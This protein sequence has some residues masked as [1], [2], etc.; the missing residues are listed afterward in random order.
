[1]VHGSQLICAVAVALLMLLGFAGNSAYSTWAITALY[2]AI[3]TFT[4]ND[5]SGKI[6]PII[7]INAILLTLL[8]GVFYDARRLLIPAIILLS[9]FI[10]KIIFHFETDTVMSF[11]TVREIAQI[12]AFFIFYCTALLFLFG[13]SKYAKRISLAF[14]VINIAFIKPGRI[15]NTIFDM[16]IVYGIM[17]VFIT[18]ITIRQRKYLW[19]LATTV[20][21]VFLLAQLPDVHSAAI[22]TPINSLNQGIRTADNSTAFNL[23]QFK[24]DRPINFVEQPI[25]PRDPWTIKL[26][27]SMVILLHYLEKVIVP[28]PLAFYYGYKFIEPQSISNPIPLL[29][30]GIYLLLISALIYFLR[31]NKTISLGIGIYLISVA[32]FSNYF[33]FVPGIVADRFLLTASLGW[34]IIMPAALVRFFNI[35]ITRE[36]LKVSEFP[37]GFIYSFGIVLGLYSFMTISRNFDWKD[38][39]SL[40]KH[41]IS[42]VE[43]SSQAHNLLALN[44]MQKSYDIA[45]PMA[46]KASRLEALGHFKKAVEIYP[47]FY[48]ATYDIAR[49]F[50]VLHENDSSIFYFKKALAI[51]SGNP[52]PALFIG[53]MLSE[54]QQYNEAIP[55]LQYAVA[56]TTGNYEAYD[57]L[58]FAYFR[59]NDYKQSIAVNIAAISKLP[60]QPE[61]YINIAHVYLAW[62]Q[63]DSAKVY[64]Q[65]ALSISPGNTAAM[66]LLRQIP[67]K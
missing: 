60:M 35:D 20:A 26:G 24:Q 33:V 53:Q 51:D 25:S 29:S 32:T 52:N 1:V 15:P 19:F 13:K 47:H 42:Y 3:G 36:R 37:K 16:L 12:V 6:F 65:K 49:V 7:G 46:Q 61:P 41:D 21:V 10:I 54:K 48:N 27:T 66:Q 18:K 59:L 4:V 40:S 67:A 50:N 8:M 31:Y 34:C 45:D 28:F 43:N 58:S 38:Y 11:G 17:Y 62:Q 22:N 63:T 55:Y 23:V 30:A 39:A 14:L 9:V 44:L 56:H 2:L 5:Y 57:K 64:L